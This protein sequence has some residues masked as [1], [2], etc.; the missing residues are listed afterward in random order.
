MKRCSK[1]TEYKP[2]SEFNKNSAKK[3]GLSNNCKECNKNYLKSHY[4]KNKNKYRKRNKDRRLHLRELVSRFKRM[5]GCKFCGEKRS[6]VLDFHHREG[7]DKDREVS[8]LITYDHASIPKL[9]KE[10]AKCDVLC[11][12]CHRDLHYKE[13]ISKVE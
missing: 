9:K 12:N 6:W 13:S 2:I 1:C 4:R 7:E 5:K 3:D 10:I 11:A 8:K